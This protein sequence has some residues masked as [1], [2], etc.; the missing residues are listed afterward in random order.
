MPASIAPVTALTV[1]AWWLG[2]LG[3][4]ELW[5]RYVGMGGTR[6]LDAL[7]GYLEGPASWPASE[8]NVLTQVLNERL[9]DRGC[10]SLAPLRELDQEGD[11][12][13]PHV[14]GTLGDFS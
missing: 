8:H 9:W 5:C 1:I 2:N 6:S 10:S 4:I 3:L 12:S 13:G 7:A 11:G 14:D